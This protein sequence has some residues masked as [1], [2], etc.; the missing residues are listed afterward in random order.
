M[1]PLLIFDLDGTLAD[2]SH[3]LIAALNKVLIDHLET[4][5]EASSVQHLISKGADGL[6]GA[7]FGSDYMAMSNQKKQ[8]LYNAFVAYYE[9]GML[10]EVVLYPEVKSTLDM[11]AEQGFKMAICS[12]KN[13]G[14]VETILEHL[15]IKHHFLA[16]CGG[17]FL[18]GIKKPDY[19]HVLGTMKEAGFD[20]TSRNAI[21]IGDAMSDMNAAKNT[22]IPS[23]FVTYGY[24]DVTPGD[25][26]ADIIVHHAVELPAA[27]LTLASRLMLRGVS[28]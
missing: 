12:N 24:G 27:I 13:T 9:Q 10:N 22:G 26:G 16:V 3:D 20:V 8:E 2:T 21:F 5:V 1:K 25:S 11:L 7:G 17:D 23:V 6:L 28:A 18:V 15:Q 4:P 19:R 14:L